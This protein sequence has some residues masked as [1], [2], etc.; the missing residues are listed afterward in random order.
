MKPVRS[1]KLLA[2]LY[3]FLLTGVLAG[4]EITHFSIRYLGMTVARVTMT[5]NGDSLMIHATSGGVGSIFQRMENHYRIAY[6]DDYVPVSYEK[7]IDQ[8]DWFEDRM[9][10]YDHQRE[11]AIRTSRIDPARNRSYHAPAGV[12]DFFSALHFLRSNPQADSLLLDAAGALWQGIVTPAGR[13]EVDDRRCRKVKVRFC[14]I[15]SGQ[16]ERS[17]LLTNNLVHPENELTLWFSLEDSGLPLQAVYEMSPFNVS[18]L[19]ESVRT[20]RE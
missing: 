3:V 15:T 12:R 19:L 13:D 5:D 10:R 1:S 2:L 7:K 4:T 14:Q 11:R 9:I 16:P 17:D 6:K 20:I 18:W 8:G